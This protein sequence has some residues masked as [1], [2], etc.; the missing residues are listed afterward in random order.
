MFPYQRSDRDDFVTIHKENFDPDLVSED[1][2]VKVETSQKEK[3]IRYDMTSLTHPF[4][5]VRN[6]MYTLYVDFI[7]S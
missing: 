2:F 4:Y 1:D 7:L 5:Y 3:E 6:F